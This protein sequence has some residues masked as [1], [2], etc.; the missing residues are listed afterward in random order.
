[1]NPLDPNPYAP[2]SAVDAVV[3]AA[4]NGEL[5]EE[6]AEFDQAS[7]IRTSLRWL[8]ICS[9]SAAP[10]FL[11]GLGLTGGR[12][13]GMVCGVAVFVVGYTLLDFRTAGH[14]IRGDRVVRRTLRIAYGTRILFSVLFPVALYLDG[15][16]GIVAIALIRAVTGFDIT[17]SDPIGFGAAFITTLVQGGVLNAVLAAYA[18]VVHLLQR[19]VIGLRR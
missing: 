9:V 16:C 3:A 4:E 10:S 12:A 2:A 5:R 6:A 17:V 13:A 14:P 1:M 19:A 11:F 8:L 15:M 7:W 18:L